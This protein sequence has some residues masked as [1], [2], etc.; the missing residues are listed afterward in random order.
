MFRRKSNPSI[1][2]SKL[3][4]L[5]APGVEIVGAVDDLGREYHKALF[6]VAPVLEGSGTKIKVL[7]A[8]M[9]GKALVSSPHA[10]RGFSGLA[11]GSGVIVAADAAA[12]TAHCVRLFREPATAL[13]LGEL[14]ARA[15]DESHSP[16]SF[17]RRVQADLQM[18][19]ERRSARAK[20]ASAA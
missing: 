12:M 10:I 4:S 18:V 13:E 11:Q 14:G 2:V 9:Y 5:I 20:P 3:S 17:A 6:G 7:E 15:I 19:A 16:A 1:E 8:L